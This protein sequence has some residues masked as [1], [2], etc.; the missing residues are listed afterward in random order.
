MN[1]RNNLDLFQE[2]IRCNQD[3]YLWSYTPDMRLISTS[4][5][6]SERNGDYI[7]MDDLTVHIQA[8]AREGHYPLILSTFLNLMWI[9]A[10]EREHDTIQAIHML[11]PF[12]SGTNSDRKIKEML[13]ERNWSVQS[14]INVMKGLEQIPIIPSNLL[15][16]YACMLHYCISKEHISR[17]DLQYLTYPLKDGASNNDAAA[18]LKNISGEHL[19]IYAS[20]QTFLKLFREGNP[21]YRQALNKSSLLSSGVKAS[22][23]SAVETAR[24]NLMVMLTLISRAAIEG[25]VSP[26]V[27]YNLCDYY[28]QRIMD[29][30]SVSDTSGLVQT[31]LD[32]YFEHIQQVRTATAISKPVQSCCDYITSHITE[33]F[34]IDFLA[35]RAGYTEYYFSRKFKQEMGMSISEYIKQEKIK[36]AALLLSTTTLS[37]QDISNELAFNSRSY[38]SDSFQKVMKESPG[39]YRKKHLKI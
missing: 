4:C 2:L 10:F 11:G 32:D 17:K 19:G 5:P 33:Q 8:Y 3:L 15:M 39:E 23:A 31:F 26:A 36:R 34:T 30:G 14:K 24:Y 25:G 12:F 9:A 29:A 16:Q 21:D 18:D 6:D 22:A 35:A 27:S 1:V 28:S 38:F 7:F 13:D 37:I 20:E